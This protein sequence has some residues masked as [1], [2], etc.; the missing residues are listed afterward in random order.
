ME[1]VTRT[2]DLYAG[3]GVRPVINATCHWTR[4]GG[5]IMPPPVLDA[6]R[7]AADISVDVNELQD[8]ASTLIVRHTH[9]EAGYVVSGCAAAL[10]IGAA[11]IM[12]GDD[13]RKMARLPDTTGLKNEWIA[14]RMDRRKASDGEEFAHYGYAQAV[15]GA[16]GRFVEVGDREATSLGD[17]E[18]A[19]GPETAGIYW[20]G[21]D[22]HG[23]PLTEDV[24]A[25]AHRHALPILIDASNILPPPKN[26][27]R[28]IDAGADWRE[29]GCSMCLAMNPDKLAPGER[30]ASTSN[31]NFEGR[32]GPGGRTHLVSPAV[33]A[34]TAV[35][36]T[37][38]AP[39]DLPALS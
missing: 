38:A 8:A 34:A 12:T 6:M 30:S 22:H 26:L 5:T 14:R 39:A 36:G 3:L 15:R 27:H 23:V 7:A 18:A 37:L 33:A 21:V 17:I 10:M 31:R 19:I 35:V 29:A 13:A 20:Q 16:G 4:F 11:A 9:A 28:F 24:I 2:R 1:S 25:L 32:Q